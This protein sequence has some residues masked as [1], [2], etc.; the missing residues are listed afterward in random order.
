MYVVGY[1]KNYGGIRSLK[2]KLSKAHIHPSLSLICWAWTIKNKNI[3]SVKP[4]WVGQ[5]VKI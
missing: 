2:T 4:S 1:E 5:W 3:P